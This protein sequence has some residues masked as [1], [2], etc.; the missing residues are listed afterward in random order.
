MCSDREVHKGDLHKL[1]EQCCVMKSKER[2]HFKKEEVPAL[3]NAEEPRKMTESTRLI[4]LHGSL[5][6]FARTAKS[7]GTIHFRE[8]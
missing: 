8:G 1:L 2:Q 7:S 3:P 4:W 5:L 6:V